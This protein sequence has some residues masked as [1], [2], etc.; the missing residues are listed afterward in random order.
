LCRQGFEAF[1]PSRPVKRRW[2]DRIRTVDAPIF[3][4]YLFCRFPLS[5]RLR[6]LNA[7]GVAQIIGAG[8]TPIPIS[9]T[10]IQSVKTL[11]SSKIALMPWPYLRS[12]QRVW[13]ERGPLAGVEGVVV[14]A[15]DGKPRVVVA[16]TLLQRAVAAQIER[17]WISRVEAAGN[18]LRG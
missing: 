7:P 6:V 18:P 16:I 1:L 14:Q 13:M 3:P 15:E 12:G 4:G 9:E 5:E 2:S 8:R 17:D 11:V 10:E